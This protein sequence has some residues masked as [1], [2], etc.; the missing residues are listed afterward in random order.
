MTVVTLS[1]V[2]TCHRGRPVYGCSDRKT[3]ADN[4]HH[5]WTLEARSVSDCDRHNLSLSAAQP[6]PAYSTSSSAVYM[7][8]HAIMAAP[9]TRWHTPQACL[10]DRVYTL[11]AAAH[12]SLMSLWRSSGNTILHTG[13]TTS[14]L[15]RCRKMKILEYRK[16]R[17]ISLVL[18]FTLRP[19]IRRLSVISA[20][21]RKLRFIIAGMQVSEQYFWQPSN[22]IDSVICFYCFL[23]GK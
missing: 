2:I 19:V 20:G 23:L 4:G 15:K 21:I 7:H 17:R 16:R 6:G 14:C 11:S 5:P 22:C 13:S 1:G 3:A 8:N 9:W 18:P 10:M 12:I